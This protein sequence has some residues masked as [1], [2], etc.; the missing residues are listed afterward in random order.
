M[1]KLSLCL[2]LVLSLSLMLWGCGSVPAEKAPE[3]QAE[4][5]A[6]TTA[7]AEESTEPQEAPEETETADEQADDEDRELDLGRIEDGV[8][9]NTYLGISFT[10]EEGWIMQD[11]G[12]LVGALDDIDEKMLKGTELEQYIDQYSHMMVLQA[13]DPEGLANVNIVYS[14]QTDAEKRIFREMTNQDVMDMLL[15]QRDTLVQSFANSGLQTESIEAVELPFAGEDVPAL[16]ILGN[17]QGIDLCILQISEFTLGN[18]SAAISITAGDEAQALEVA[19]MFQP[20]NPGS[21][22]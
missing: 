19:D 11:A 18:Y 15:S 8:Y 16:R 2:V 12:D 20:L 3:T 22:G 4:T 7:E 6:E 5:A 17:V 10:P 1:K 13:V 21:A 14:E 9:T